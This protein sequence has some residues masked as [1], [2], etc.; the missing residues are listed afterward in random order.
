MSKEKLKSQVGSDEGD[1]VSE[2]IVVPVL[3]LRDVVVYLSR[4][5]ITTCGYG[6]RS[7]RRVS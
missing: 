5:G 1:K 2:S 7:C 3:P 6:P 4:A